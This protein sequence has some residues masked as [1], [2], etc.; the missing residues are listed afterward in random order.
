MNVVQVT[1][2][3]A[4]LVVLAGAAI[5]VFAFGD[6]DSSPPAVKAP[7]ATSVPL[8]QPASPQPSPTDVPPTAT[9][10]TAAAPLPD[11]TG[12]E[13]IR[14]TPYRSDTEREF[15]LR[16]CAV[17]PTT[18][19][20][21]AS[22]DL[23]DTP[24]ESPEDCQTNIEIETS[25]SDE[26]YVVAGTNIDEISDSL[27]ANAPQLGGSPAY[28]LTE[29]S[30]GLEGSFCRGANSCSLGEITIAAD[31]TVTTPNLLTADQLS[32]DLA[33]VWFSYADQV[34]I[35][36][37]RHVRILQEGLNEIRRQLLLIGE[38][39]NCDALNHEV[40]KIWSLG[41]SQME[42]RQSAFHA[43]DA[44]GSGGLVVQ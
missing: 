28:G 34:S 36:E 35:H 15:F 27:D 1:I 12:C 42:Q 20:R 21:Q 3:A 2:T 37:G 41:N 17:Q 31:V 16:S 7:A 43:A 5:A 13:E 39:P 40:D 25:R 44:N 23:P 9:P 18:T 26:T 8:T 33:E 10:V 6:G 19:S 29:Y 14:G 32:P 11:R 38:E 30:Y 4:F 24:A 22:I